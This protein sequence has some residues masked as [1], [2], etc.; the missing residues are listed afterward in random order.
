M[1]VIEYRIA[2]GSHLRCGHKHR[3]HSGAERCARHHLAAAYRDQRVG[4][5][6][7]ASPPYVEIV[8]LGGD[9]EALQREA[10]L[11]NRELDWRETDEEE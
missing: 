6:W 10:E 5:G 2:G 9:L 11:A 7:Y 3:T 4:R 1:Y 8:E